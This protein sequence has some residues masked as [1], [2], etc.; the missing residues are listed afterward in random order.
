MGFYV[1]GEFSSEKN[2]RWDIIEFD[3]DIKQID[4]CMFC[5]PVA[6]FIG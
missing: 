3:I 6:Y 5:F 4:S 2:V 1:L